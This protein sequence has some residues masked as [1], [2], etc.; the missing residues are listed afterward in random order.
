MISGRSPG[1]YRS[2]GEWFR[3]SRRLAALEDRLARE[4]ADWEA[5]AVHVVRGGRR[6]L[7]NRHNLARA[8]LTETG[9]RERWEASRWF[10]AADG[11]SG[12]R[13]GNE[14]IRVTPD[15]EVS[16]RLPAPLA[17]HANTAHGRYVLSSKVAFAHRGEEWRGPGVGEHGGG[18]RNHQPL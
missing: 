9:W 6:L 15:G 7:G 3:K 1:G 4:K 5:G 8:Q 11:E 17:Q 18:H 14:T 13:Y 2:R 12:K 16:I 10:L